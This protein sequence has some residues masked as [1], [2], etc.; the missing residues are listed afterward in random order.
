MQK[1]KFKEKENNYNFMMSHYLLPP[2]CTSIKYTLLFQ[3]FTAFCIF[4]VL[5]V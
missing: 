2:N 3:N 4:L 5:P 1:T